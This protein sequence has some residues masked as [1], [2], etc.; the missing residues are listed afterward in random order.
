[1]DVSIIVGLIMA[2][3]AIGGA[4]LYDKLKNE[5]K[6]K[7][8]F[9]SKLEKINK[10]FER[11]NKLDKL[12]IK[13]GES[14]EDKFGKSISIEKLK[15]KMGL[16]SKISDK[17]SNISLKK[18]TFNLS[19]AAREDKLKEIDEKL[20]EVVEE[21]PKP[22]EKVVELDSQEVDKVLEEKKE[23]FAIEDNL[24]DEMETATS[25]E[26]DSISE[27]DIKEED[28]E[29]LNADITI[30]T[31]ELEAE[32]GFDVDERQEAEMIAETD[33]A[34]EIEFDEK[35]ALLASLEKEITVKKE[36][37]LDLLRDLRNENLDVKEI[38]RELKE[39]LEILNQ[40]KGKVAKA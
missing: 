12:K 3:G 31:D 6:I 28:L 9:S 37:K 15:N 14:S 21:T 7:V 39:V 36:E 40:F 10:K 18:P 25:L 20:K 29:G 35:D 11:I 5:G 34:E 8:D 24:I 30:D 22:V 32:F 2:G 23:E 1:L 16:F 26:Q 4:T 19:K 13:K 17:L 27:M 33:T 38:E